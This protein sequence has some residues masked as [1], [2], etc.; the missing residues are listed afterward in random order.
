VAGAGRTFAAL[1][2]GLDAGRRATRAAPSAV[3]R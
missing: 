1:Q 3:T 2:T